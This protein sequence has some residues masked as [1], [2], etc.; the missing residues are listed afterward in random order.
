[1]SKNF[2]E[3]LNMILSYSFHRG[4]IIEIVLHKFTTLKIRTQSK[5]RTRVTVSVLSNTRSFHEDLSKKT[6]R[7]REKINKDNSISLEKEFS[8]FIQQSLHMKL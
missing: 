5:P 6:M 3:T 7:K 2:I 1:M 8:Y 4:K